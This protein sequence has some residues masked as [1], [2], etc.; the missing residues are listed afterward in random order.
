MS[1]QDAVPIHLA[2]PDLDPS[3]AYRTGQAYAAIASGT[4]GT[5][6]EMAAES[7]RAEE[8]SAAGNELST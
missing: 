7:R 8:S 1:A 4:G 6:S 2:H 5:V 3:A